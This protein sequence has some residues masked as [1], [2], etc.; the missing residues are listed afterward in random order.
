MKH[1]GRICFLILFLTAL[2]SAGCQRKGLHKRADITVP[3]VATA[4][5]T[6]SAAPDITILDTD[7]N[8]LRLSDL[9]GKPIVLKFFHPDHVHAVEDLILL[10]NAYDLH[11]EDVQFVILTTRDPASLV[12]PE[13]THISLP[14]FTDPDGSAF[15]AYGIVDRPVTVF[16]DSDGFIAAKAQD[17]IDKETLDFGMKMF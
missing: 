8:S 3:P 16:I 15:S 5:Y 7:G 2:L 9:F 10:Q 12:F 11:R 1:S 6:E 4:A 13:D 14:F 17:S